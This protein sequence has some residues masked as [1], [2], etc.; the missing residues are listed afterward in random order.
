M[1]V[2]DDQRK[3]INR[4]FWRSCFSKRYSSGVLRNLNAD[5]KEMLLLRSKKPSTL[6]GFS[7]DLDKK[8]FTSN[9]FGMGNVNTKTFVLMLAQNSPKSFVSGAP[10]NLAETL[11]SSNRAEFHHLMPR[12]FLRKS[13]QI[14]IDESVLANFAF[15]SRSDNR[16]LGGDAP[17]AYQAKMALNKKEILESALCP[18]SLFNDKYD[19]FIEERV[20]L[21]LKKLRFYVLNLNLPKIFKRFPFALTHGAPPACCSGER[22][23][24]VC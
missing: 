23:S 19:V 6:G 14:S 24:S 16:I 15:L 21:L 8:F 12:S 10:V 13:A 5:I 20:D 9:T 7:A 1:D 2:S 17:S 11:K 3:Q 4:W 18:V 22:T